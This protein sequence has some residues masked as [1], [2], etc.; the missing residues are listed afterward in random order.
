[1]RSA[2]SCPRSSGA[3]STAA[4]AM[5]EVAISYKPTIVSGIALSEAIVASNVKL[6]CKQS[7]S[8]AISRNQSQ[9]VAISRNPSQS[10]IVISRNQSSQS[11]AISRNQSQ[12][13]AARR[14]SKALTIESMNGFV[15]IRSPDCTS[16]GTVCSMYGRSRAAFS[17]PKN[18]WMA[19]SC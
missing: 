3:P 2:P 1:M 11:V 12:S 17:S 10:V 9:S 8:V 16:T 19:I 14:H 5:A 13:V 6:T 15:E 4:S 18:V 7:Q